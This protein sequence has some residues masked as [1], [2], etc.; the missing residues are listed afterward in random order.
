MREIIIKWQDFIKNNDTGFVYDKMHEF[1]STLTRANFYDLICYAHKKYQDEIIK[2]KED[3]EISFGKA[4]EL[5]NLSIMGMR[6][7]LLK[8]RDEGKTHASNN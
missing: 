3:E 5:L 6:E 4:A 1:V 8:R 2:R 7:L